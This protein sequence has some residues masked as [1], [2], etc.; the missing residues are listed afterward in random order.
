MADKP[1]V[2]VDEDD[3]IVTL[4]FNRPEKRNAMSPDLHRAMHENLTRMRFDKRVR[5]LIVTGAGESFCAG[6]DLKEY[7]FNLSEDEAQLERATALGSQSCEERSR[8]PRDLPHLDGGTIGRTAQIGKL[9]G[10]RDL[11]PPPEPAAA[12]LGCRPP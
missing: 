7:F 11:L 9:P 5:V 12:P 2:L 3:G 1:V 6:Q 10:R 8:P 4:T